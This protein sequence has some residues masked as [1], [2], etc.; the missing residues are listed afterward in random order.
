[1]RL[2]DHWIELYHLE[3]KL[4]IDPYIRE[5]LQPASYDVTLD[6][7]AKLFDRQATAVLD[8]SAPPVMRIV[9]LREAPHLGAGEFML[10]ST[11]ERIYCDSGLS[12]RVDGKSS[13]GRLGLFVENA[14]YIDPGFNGQITLELFNASPFPMKLVPGMRIA[15]V[16]FEELKDKAV[17]VYGSPSLRSR[18][19]DQVGP[20]E[21]RI[22][23]DFE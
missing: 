3:K 18:Y 17:R 15:Q 6:W 4:D 14:G 8:L 23:K 11:V 9:D 10:V 12:A 2:P 1:M 19:Q 20:V 7:Q 16:A 13:L 21:S 22:Y 5:N